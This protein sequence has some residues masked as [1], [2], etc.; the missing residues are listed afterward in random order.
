MI[1]KLFIPLSAAL[2]GVIAQA[3]ASFKK[4]KIPKI[5]KKLDI[6]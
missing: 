1:F 4:K 2:K 6:K 5:L 3:I